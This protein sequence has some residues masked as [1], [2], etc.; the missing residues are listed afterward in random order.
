VHLSHFSPF[1]FVCLCRHLLHFVE[2]SAKFSTIALFVCL[3][4]SLSLS[5]RFCRH[6]ST[7]SSPLQQSV[8]C[9]EW[10]SYSLTKGAS[11]LLLWF[12]LHENEHIERQRQKETEG[13]HLLPDLQSSLNVCHDCHVPSIKYDAL[14]TCLNNFLVGMLVHG[15]MEVFKMNY[16]SCSS[17]ICCSWYKFHHLWRELSCRVLQ[18]ERLFFLL[19]GVYSLLVWNFI[20]GRRKWWNHHDTKMELSS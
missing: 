1:L 7:V 5:L 19:P 18:K 20:I 3:F 12:V 9:S 16:N 13:I 15:A 11:K 8:C 6:L 4:L 2:W 17:S 10:Q 14:H